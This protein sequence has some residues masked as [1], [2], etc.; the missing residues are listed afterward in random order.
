MPGIVVRGLS[1]KTIQRL[2][3]RAKRNGRSLQGEA[4]RLLEQSAGAEDVA[5][6]LDRW[7]DRFANRRFSPSAGL[8]REDRAR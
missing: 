2:K 7:K 3:D 5:A 8:I 1:P 4:K 6:L